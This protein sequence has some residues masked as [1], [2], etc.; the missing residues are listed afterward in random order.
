MSPE[1]EH[2][3]TTLKTM[4]G[5]TPD[6][7]RVIYGRTSLWTLAAPLFFAAAVYFVMWAAS[8]GDALP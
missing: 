1:S 5:F 2:P 3:F 4:K 6:A 7:L 8:L